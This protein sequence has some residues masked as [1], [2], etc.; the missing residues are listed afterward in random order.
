MKNYLSE[1]DFSDI[2]IYLYMAVFA[3]CLFVS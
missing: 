1:N 2:Y 3:E